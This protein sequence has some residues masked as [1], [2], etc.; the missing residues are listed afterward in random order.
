[1]HPSIISELTVVKVM[2]YMYALHHARDSQWM[3]YSL[4]RVPD[5]T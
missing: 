3:H 2:T 5:L 4:S 1:M